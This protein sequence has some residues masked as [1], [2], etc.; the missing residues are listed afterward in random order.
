MDGYC[1]LQRKYHLQNHEAHSS[2]IPARVSSW[3]LGSRVADAHS[4]TVLHRPKKLRLLLQLPKVRKICKHIKYTKQVDR[5]V[6]SYSMCLPFHRIILVRHS[7]FLYYVVVC[8][9]INNIFIQH[10]TR[11][12]PKRAYNTCRKESRIEMCLRR[13]PQ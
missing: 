8:D 9:C 1:L 7:R 13:T 6:G 3:P 12:K 10:N 4:H 5:Q 11:R 2:F